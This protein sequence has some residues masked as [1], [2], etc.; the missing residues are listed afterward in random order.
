[1]LTHVGPQRMATVAS[2]VSSLKEEIMARFNVTVRP[3]NSKDRPHQKWVVNIYHPVDG[4]SRLFFPTKEQA[5]TEMV[6]QWRE[7]E[8][9][10]L[11]A[12]DLSAQQRLEALDAYKRIE[13][14]GISLTEVV[15]DF[16]ERKASSTATMR[17]L[18]AL[19]LK[20]RESLGRSKLHLTGL[21]TVLGTFNQTFGDRRASDIS[22]AQIQDWLFDQKG[23][24]RTI[25]HHRAK[26]HGAFQFG[27]MRKIVRENPVASVEKRKV[28]TGKI[29]ILTPDQMR[30]LLTMSTTLNDAGLVATF[31]I[32]GFAGL[33]PEEVARL[34]RS[35]LDLD[36]GHIDCG[37]E[38]TKTG[39]QRYVKIEPVLRSWLERVCHDLP[40]TG[41]LQG[42]NFRRRFD[43]ARRLAGFQ[44]SSEIYTANP[45]KYPDAPK[46]NLE[47]WP[48]DAFRHSY[49]SYHLA[50]FE[51]AAAL[52][53]QMGHRTTKMIF[54]NYR[55]RVKK[56]D[57]QLWWGML[58]EVTP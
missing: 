19:Y 50:V 24:P 43:L 32:G 25:N 12:M 34:G 38:I 14:F 46:D 9:Y 7:F 28:K 2:P 27:V 22:S 1:M 18:S 37:E 17:E 33:R 54:S 40:A 30:A 13:P 5:E 10:G 31:A 20:S 39:M 57:G 11:A 16:V 44:V 49:A 51:D 42:S 53:L 29:G 47:P 35:A 58:P 3:Y 52:A 55:A 6:S 48:H 4:R 56:T 45:E 41:L 8:R 15:R 23:Q 26:L 21:R 36:H